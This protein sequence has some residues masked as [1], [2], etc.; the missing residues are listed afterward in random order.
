MY[1]FEMDVSESFARAY[2]NGEQFCTV[3]N[4]GVTGILNT[5]HRGHPHVMD[6]ELFWNAFFDWTETLTKVEG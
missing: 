1:T 3:Q 5:L 4:C 6:E 2:Y